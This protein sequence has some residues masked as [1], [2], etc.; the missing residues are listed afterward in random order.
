[1]LSLKALE[2]DL[3]QALSQLPVLP[4]LVVKGG[5]NLYKVFSVY[6]HVGFPHFMAVSAPN[7]LLSIRAPVML[8]WDPL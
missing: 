3:L 2:E 7:F 4:W 6:H 1:M 8:D 5:S